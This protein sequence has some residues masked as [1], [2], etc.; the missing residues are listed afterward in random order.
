MLE[1]HGVFFF[2]IDHFILKSIFLKE[3]FNFVLFF[4]TWKK[5]AY[6]HRYSQS[7]LACRYRRIL[8]LLEFLRLLCL[9]LLWRTSYFWLFRL[10]LFLFCKNFSFKFNLRL[11]FTKFTAW[12]VVHCDA[13][14]KL[15]PHFYF[16]IVNYVVIVNRNKTISNI[17]FVLNCLDLCKSVRF[18]VSCCQLELVLLFVV[19][20]V[21]FCL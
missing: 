20:V 21:L 2:D 16:R 4:F 10:N 17:V 11:F 15:W 14:N 3:I 9:N 18:H 19:L 13:N 7:C 8:Q 6:F 1:F 5:K 12:F